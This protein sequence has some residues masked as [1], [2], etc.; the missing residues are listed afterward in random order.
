MDWSG[1][2][3]PSCRKDERQTVEQTDKAAEVAIIGA[4]PAGLAAAEMLSLSGHRVTVFDAMP[5]VGRKF[6]LAGK[7][8]LNLTH[9]EE[10][11]RFRQR[12]DP[13]DAR[14]L[15]SVDA[16]DGAS[17]RAWADG[18]GA[19]TFTGSSGRVFPKVMKASPLLRAW[20]GALGRQGVTIRTRHRWLGFSGRTQHF[21]TPD[22]PESHTF[23]ATLLCLGG[24]SWPKLGSDA[25]WVPILQAAG[26]EIQAFEPANCGFDVAWSES[27]GERFAG[28]PVK[29]VTATTDSS[30][31][32][33]EFVI[34]PNG[35]EGSLV[36]AH[37]AD[38]RRALNRGEP[39][40]LHIDLM[41]GRSLE[42]LARDL[43]RQD[44]K[45]SLISL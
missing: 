5:S 15:A 42:R 38:L 8:G 25:G 10:A 13:Q 44:G 37:A 26:V 41:P 2:S 6:L 29:S 3:P 45:A 40:T 11:G 31:T 27:F 23:D 32:Q 24:A 33:G 21:L 39:A 16:F 18:Y 4:G 35:I 20:L 28:A 1:L 17:V 22:G 7:S 43:S 12:F 34:T 9:A 30:T 36:Y 19:E 14:L